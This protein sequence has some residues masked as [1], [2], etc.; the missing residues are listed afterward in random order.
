MS[1]ELLLI[2]TES[3]LPPHS[4][5]SC[6]SLPT[7]S[8]ANSV[9]FTLHTTVTLANRSTPVYLPLQIS[10][11]YF[12][13]ISN[14]SFL[15]SLIET[16]A[17]A[18]KGASLFDILKLLPVTQVFRSHCRTSCQIC[19]KLKRTSVVRSWQ[20]PSEDRCGGHVSQQ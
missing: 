15:N 5:N 17:Q 20:L 13:V 16:L 14:L 4:I 19:Q 9:T 2:D 12:N 7:A 18:V 6:F 10:E 8:V 1:A 11:M 3:V